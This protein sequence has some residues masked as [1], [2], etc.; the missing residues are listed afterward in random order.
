[1][2]DVV[3]VDL[4]LRQRRQQPM[5]Q[6]EPVVLF[7]AIIGCLAILHRLTSGGSDQAASSDA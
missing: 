1:V 4:D 3:A 6:R 5:S 7:A 2:N